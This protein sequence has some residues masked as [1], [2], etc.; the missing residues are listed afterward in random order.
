MS[1][2]PRASVEAL[3]RKAGESV[4]RREFKGAFT[5][6][7]AAVEQLLAVGWLSLEREASLRMLLGPH[8][9]SGVSARAL[10][11][12]LGE[13]DP[14]DSEA[15]Y[16]PLQAAFRGVGGREKP[17][18]P[19]LIAAVRRKLPGGLRLI[20]SG[21]RPCLAMHEAAARAVIMGGPDAKSPYRFDIREYGDFGRDWM[22][23]SEVEAYLN[24][25]AQDIAWLRRRGCLPLIESEKPRFGRECVEQV[26]RQFMTSQEAAARLGVLA[27]EVWELLETRPEIR[28][29]GQ[30]FH[31]REGLEAVLRAEAHNPVWWN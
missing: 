10:L 6:P 11:D 16:I 24:C 20:T 22:A 5:L 21:S 27:K 3:S 14:A 31:E 19:V 30:G 18:A 23:P 8:T 1:Q 4:S 26:G 12:E 17:W 13:L 28:S 15:G 9:L 7:D 2:L 29:I 25:T